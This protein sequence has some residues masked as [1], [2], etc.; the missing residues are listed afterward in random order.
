MKSSRETE[1]GGAGAEP[2]ADGWHEPL[3]ERSPDPTYAPAALALGLG[4]AFWGALT[5]WVVGLTGAALVA[6]SLREWFAAI[7][8]DWRRGEG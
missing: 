4:L 8:A 6:W 1:S 7:R 3:P 5:G 2:S